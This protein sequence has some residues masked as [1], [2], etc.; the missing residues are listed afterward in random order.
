MLI[1]DNNFSTSLTSLLFP[2]LLF[3]EGPGA[4]MGRI[5]ALLH[6]TDAHFSTRLHM[7]PQHRFAFLLF[8]DL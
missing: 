8:G 7:H 5:I 4:G 3:R 1:Q 6:W 2:L